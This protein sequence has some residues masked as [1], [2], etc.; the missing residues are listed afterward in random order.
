MNSFL[1]NKTKKFILQNLTAFPCPQIAII[2]GSGIK[3]FKDYKPLFS[4]KYSKLPFLRTGATFR[5]GKEV[6]GH[7]GILKLYKIKDKNVLVFSGRRH[8]YEG[9]SIVDVVSNVRL[10]YELGIKK[11]LI[12]NAAGGLNK[13]LKP[14]DLMLIAGYINLMQPT[15]RGLLNGIVQSPAKV[16]TK[17]SKL[18]GKISKPMVKL[19]RGIY[20]GMQGPSY[21]TY[22]EIKLLKVLGAS[23]VGMSTIPEMIC[24][25]S[26]GMDYAG[27]SI[28]S[29][30]W[31]KNHKPSHEKVLQN[32]E[33]ANEK[34]NNLILRLLKYL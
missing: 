15:E 31:G 3:L 9:C 13:K 25:K 2:T 19:S 33:K 34:L 4:I 23:A 17:L 26:L 24:A 18:I 6:K 27:I 14:S 7:E 28:I 32:V 10:A 1:F 16:K 20:A 29:N 8:L 12:T 5:R 30:V 11:V 21:E 22:A